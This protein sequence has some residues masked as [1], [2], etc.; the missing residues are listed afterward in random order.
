MR[1]P[2]V[3]QA[4]MMGAQE[5]DQR[6]PTLMDDELERH[7]DILSVITQ[8]ETED[9]LARQMAVFRQQQFWQWLAQK[10]AAQA[11]SAAEQQ[12]RAGAIKEE[13]KERP[14]PKRS[15]AT[16]STEQ[17]FNPVQEAGTP[18]AQSMMAADKAFANRVRAM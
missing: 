12:A 18:S 6:H 7:I 5:V 15:Q 3:Q 17:A 9:P 13:D 14:A 11:E 16:G 10:Q 1:D 8:D 4:A 2:M